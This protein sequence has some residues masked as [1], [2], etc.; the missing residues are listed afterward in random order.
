MST[1]S[2]PQNTRALRE[3]TDLEVGQAE[4]L[5]MLGRRRRNKLMALKAERQRRAGRPEKMA[6][7][8][9]ESQL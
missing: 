2:W 3:L 5:E 4:H 6:R 9:V 7:L 1:S 8:K